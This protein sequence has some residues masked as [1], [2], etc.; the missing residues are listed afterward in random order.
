MDIKN[1][2]FLKECA[3]GKIHPIIET[4][5]IAEKNATAKIPDIIKRL[6]GSKVFLLADKNTQK[7]AGN[8]VV[9]VLC[10]NKIPYSEYVFGSDFLEPD[11]QAVGEAVMRYDNSCDIIL[12]IGSGVIN[13]IGKILSVTS[14]NPY[15]IFATAPSMDG[16]AS[17]SSSMN[18]DGLK[19]SLPTKCPDAIAGDIDILKNAPLDM[20]KSG[21]GDIIAKYVSICEWRISREVNNEYY[22]ES[23]AELI[24]SVVKNCCEN[25]EGLLKRDEKAVKAVFEGLILSGAAMAFAGLSRPASGIE[26]YIS[27]IWDMRGLEFNT[28]VS[29][30]GIQCVVGTFAA[31]KLY[32][33]VKI[34]TPD[35]EKALEYASNFSLEKWNEELCGFLGK[36]ASAMIEL[37]KKERKYDAEK[38]R[39]RLDTIIEKWDK[40]LKIIDEELP[41]SKYLAELLDLIEA[42]KSPE[43]INI[44][45]GLLPMTFKSAKDIRDKYV[46][47][48]LCYDLGIID[49]LNFDIF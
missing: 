13:D 35:R 8:A 36:G 42:P 22:C 44:D 33:Q 10:D 7:A 4:E 47:P 21:L 34:I 15:I 11:E 14:K 45:N 49:S 16:Y 23:I 39:I 30:H 46:L 26:H 17:A 9:T 5:I 40:I 31:V 20:L 32:E 41:S 28:P 12:A 1:F 19:I 37:E 38:H 29:L 27:H 3:C 48:M 6:G 24:R 25:A 43:E 2:S 18:R